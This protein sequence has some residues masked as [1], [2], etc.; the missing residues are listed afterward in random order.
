VKDSVQVGW[1]RAD[2]DGYGHFRPYREGDEGFDL[3][4]N[5]W[6]PVWIDLTP[7][8]LRPAE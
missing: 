1:V 5:G 2:G 4:L 6:I 8:P 3:A 7:L